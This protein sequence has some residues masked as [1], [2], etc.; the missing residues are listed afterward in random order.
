MPPIRESISVTISGSR[1]TLDRATVEERVRGVLA[2]PV[3]DHFVVVGGRRFPPKQVIE[4][5]TGLDRANFNTHQA[6]RTLHRLGFVTGRRGSPSYADPP[7]HAGRQE[8]VEAGALRPYMGKWVAQKGLEVLVAADTPQEV[9]EWLH[10][11]D[12]YADGMFRVPESTE[13]MAGAGPL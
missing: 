3:K 1:Y 11:H 7:K 6:Q 8:G 10:R 12:V 9:C 5:V 2:D 13:G 4:L